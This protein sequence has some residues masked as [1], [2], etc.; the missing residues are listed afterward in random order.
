MDPETS[1]L[2]FIMEECELE[3]PAARDLLGK[4]L[5]FGDD[6][7]RPVHT[8]SGGEKNKL[9]LA[10]LTHLSPNL[11]ILDEPTNHL[12]MDSREALAEVLRAYSGT[13]ILISHDRWL[14]SQ[15]TTHI[16]DVRRIGPIVFGGSYDDYRGRSTSSSGDNRRSV[17]PGQT[18]G[19]SVESPQASLSPREI[20]KEIG[21]IEKL[22]SQLE[23]DVERAEQVL[24]EMQR[25]LSHL[26]EG[27]DV[28]ALTTAYMEQE[29]LVARLLED[30][31][32]ESARL[33]ELR[34]LQGSRS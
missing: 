10:L 5:F 7:F 23:S 13:L 20:S 19:T 21:R 25:Q 15:V 11:L 26:P 8:L 34:G 31:E 3:P 9:V 18:G 28:L 4:F 24:S 12:D 33:E 14:L 17:K 32:K 1:P 30:W 29:I 6:V 2:A 22:V 16:L 27:S